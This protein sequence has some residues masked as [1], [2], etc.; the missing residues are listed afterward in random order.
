MSYKDNNVLTDIDGKPIAQYYE[1]TKDKFEELEG[2]D[3]ATHNK[4]VDANGNPYETFPVE[5][6]NQTNVE[7]PDVQRVEVTNAQTQ[8][9]VN[10]LNPVDSV[11]VDNLPNDYPDSAVK[12]E[13]ELIK[14]QQADILDK[15]NDTIDTRLTGSNVE[16]LNLADNDVVMAGASKSFNS[17]SDLGGISE[18]SIFVR[19]STR[20]DLYAYFY[21]PQKNTLARDSDNVMLYQNVDGGSRASFKTINIPVTD[22]VRLFYVNKDDEND[23]QVDIVIG[24]RT[25]GGAHND[26]ESN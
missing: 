23:A 6:T 12:A 21:V 4:I 14:Q 2:S 10:V 11:S 16:Y 3:G 1:K 22:K 15:L 26:S 24:A 8:M 20:F 7:F 5:V 19:S 17:G 25:F 9:D 18:I 13:L